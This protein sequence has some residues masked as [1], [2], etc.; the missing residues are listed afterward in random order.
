MSEYRRSS[1]DLKLHF[2]KEFGYG[3]GNGRNAK[4]CQ[5]QC[6]SSRVFH[7]IK[8]VSYSFRAKKILIKCDKYHLWWWYNQINTNDRMMKF[9]TWWHEKV[10]VWNVF[11]KLVS[12][13]V[14]KFSIHIILVEINFE[15]VDF[16]TF[17]WVWFK[18]YT[19]FDIVYEWKSNGCALTLHII[20]WTLLHY[21]LRSFWHYRNFIKFDTFHIAWFDI[22]YTF[23]KV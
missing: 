3:I 14:S 9:L 19:T 16:D 20:L 2:N 13:L 17:Q 21:L 11:S 15:Y 23:L 22:I 8:W 1:I 4:Q 6:D 7:H 5:N 18:F 10:V 12:Q